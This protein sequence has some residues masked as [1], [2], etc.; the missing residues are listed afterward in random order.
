MGTK[1]TQCDC[2]SHDT[3]EFTITRKA[4]KN[5]PLDVTL[6]VLLTT[7]FLYNVQPLS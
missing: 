4:L 2:G 3:T 6:V 5:W 7:L 1:R